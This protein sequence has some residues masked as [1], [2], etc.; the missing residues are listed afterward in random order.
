MTP[1]DSDEIL[2]HVRN[3]SNML[4]YATH[5]RSSSWSPPLVS[6]E[7]AELRELAW[8]LTPLAYATYLTIVGEYAA[9]P[10]LW[11]DEVTMGPK[12]QRRLPLLRLRQTLASSGLTPNRHAASALDSLNHEGLIDLST[13]DGRSIDP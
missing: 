1:H 12:G 13:V 4:R 10:L 11:P 5:A 6:L 8:K 9:A 3:W 7:T 2:V